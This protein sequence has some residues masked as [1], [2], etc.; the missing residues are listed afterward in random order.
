MMYDE[1]RSQEVDKENW[2][3]RFPFFSDK[4]IAV[5]F[6]RWKSN[7]LDVQFLS[8]F[9]IILSAS[10]LNAQFK[11]VEKMDNIFLHKFEFINKVHLESDII[12]KPGFFC[13]LEDKIPN[14]APL[15]LNFSLGSLD[16]TN[17]LE[18]YT[19]K[20]NPSNKQ[21]FRQ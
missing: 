12:Y 17:Y 14:T 4:R 19:Y 7:Q 9:I 13:K 18:Y 2:N 16:Y 10:T 8:I 15:K 5:A 11:S 6:L 21:Y 20:L 1:R 3:C